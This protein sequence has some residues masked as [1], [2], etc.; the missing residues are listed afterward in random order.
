MIFLNFIDCPTTFFIKWIIRGIFSNSFFLLLFWSLNNAIECFW[1]FSFLFLLIL[2]RW[3][4]AEVQILLSSI[5]AISMNKIFKKGQI[6]NWPLLK[7]MIESKGKNIF[8]HYWKLEKNV[9]K[10]YNKKF[11]NILINSKSIIK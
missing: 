4:L 6:I 5:W 7:V 3:N 1:V 2:K 8:E 10:I 9:N 11:W